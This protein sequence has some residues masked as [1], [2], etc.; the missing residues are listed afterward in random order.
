MFFLYK[1]PC[2]NCSVMPSS[3]RCSS[4]SVTWKVLLKWSTLE[5][6]H[7]TSWPRLASKPARM[8]VRQG[9]AVEP[10]YGSGSPT[11]ISQ[12]EGFRCGTRCRT[13]DRDG[14]DG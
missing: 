12:I 8:P 1:Q 3:V 7:V 2:R 14:R 9:R 4:G 13:R 5:V 11:V 10:A 6:H